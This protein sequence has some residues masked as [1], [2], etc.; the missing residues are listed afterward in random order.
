M[1]EREVRRYCDFCSKVTN[2]TE[3]GSGKKHYCHV[4]GIGIEYGVEEGT[5]I[6]DLV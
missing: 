5:M 4:C 3:S 6:I 2:Q 1:S